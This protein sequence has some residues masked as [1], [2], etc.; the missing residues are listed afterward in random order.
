MSKQI[1]SPTD[2]QSNKNIGLSF[3]IAFAALFMGAIAMGISPVFVRHAEV[4]AFASAFWRVALALP[5]L[6][7]WAVLEAR[8]RRESFRI[9]T[10]FSKIVL[11]TGTLFAGDLFFW[12]LAIM[13]TNVA[14]ATLLACLA[15]VWVVLLAGRFIGEEIT[16]RTIAGLMICL[17]GASL[18]IGTSYQLKPD[19]VLGDIF[20]L[21][22]SF[23]F[24]L[25]FLAV[26]VARRNHLAGA[27]TFSSTI[28]TTLLL[29]GVTLISGQAFLPKSLEGVGA[30]AALGIISHSGG[31]GLLAVALGSLS[32]VF[33]SLVIFIEAVAAALFGW[34]LLGEALSAGQIGGGILILSGV[35]FARPSGQ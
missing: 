12:H 5:I 24:G 18:L 15:P 10:S 7:I 27:L 33:S 35:W 4:E 11:L 20:G 28:I 9:L 25:Y 26:R 21:I 32:A 34:A 22:T 17:A 1:N 2:E 14:N 31:Q 16:K 23:F 30:L 29:F 3:P 6:L 8:K 13:N 19:N